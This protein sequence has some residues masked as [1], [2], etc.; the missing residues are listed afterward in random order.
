[1]I[2]IDTSVWID[3]F[4]GD[5]RTA[6]L[7][8]LLVQGEAAIHPWVLGELRLGHLGATFKRRQVLSD[9]GHLPASE[10][11]PLE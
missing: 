3:F 2:L 5:Q 9:L 7:S 4:R 6:S 1:M 8:H 11:Y 10:I